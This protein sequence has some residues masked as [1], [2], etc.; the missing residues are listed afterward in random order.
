MK[1]G[2][3]VKLLLKG[4][5]ISISAFAQDPPKPD[6]FYF[7]KEISAFDLTGKE[8]QFE[9][10]VKSNPADD[11]S[12]VRIY[13]VQLGKG[14]DEILPQTIR[15]ASYQE[16]IWRRYYVTLQVDQFARRIWFY[17]GVQGYGNFYFD[18]LQVLAKESND[19]LVVLDEQSE[20]F[21]QKSVLRHCIYPHD[22]NKSVRFFGDRKT[23]YQGKQ[24]LHVRTV[25]SN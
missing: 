4:L 13:A 18:Q 19:V 15:Y 24:S 7:V 2:R 11:S 22:M 9:I 21:E 25:R 5:L 12:Q 20:N 17:C 1:L 14:R 10:M 23:K 3:Y 8:V 16:G 6:Q